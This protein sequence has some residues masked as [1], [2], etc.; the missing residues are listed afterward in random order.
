M[1]GDILVRLAQGNRLNAAQLNELRD[2]MNRLE[3][4]ERR[5][6]SWITPSGGINA[7]TAK[8]SE[9]SNLSLWSPGV[10][11]LGKGAGTTNDIVT[12]TATTITFDH[13]GGAI[14]YDTGG[15]ILPGVSQPS[16]VIIPNDGIYAVTAGGG[17]EAAWVG[18]G[19]MWISIN[20][21]EV[22][23][24]LS[25]VNANIAGSYLVTP[26]HQLSTYERIFNKG[27]SIKLRVHQDSGSNKEFGFA[28][29]Q[30]RKVG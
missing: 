18:E 2:A 15:F 23:S 4:T 28:V 9:L 8:F 22:Y 26:A 20:D 29:L 6:R 21:V 5:V 27:D 1:I 16:E 11:L 17:W 10:S 12:D 19:E 24:P 3:Q 30:V 25:L 7:D 14:L 13:Q